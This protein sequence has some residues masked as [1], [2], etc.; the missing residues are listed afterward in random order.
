MARY[1]DAVCK[2]CRRERVKLFLK[3]DRCYSDKCAVDKKPY[4]PGQHGPN[5]RRAKH[6]EYGIQLR[7]KQKVKRLYG[8]LEKQ[9]R[10][11]YEK[12]SHIKGKTGENL[13]ILLERRLDNTV[14]RMGFARSLAEARQLVKHSHVMVNGEK[15]NIPSAMV[16]KDDVL[17]IREKSK[18]I[19]SIAQAGE[20]AARK[21]LVPVWLSVDHKTLSGK[22]VDNPSREQIAVPIQEQLIVEL[23]SR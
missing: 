12:A 14:F 17:T 15:C 8:L 4:A 19:A 21:G 13:L 18:N 9:F 10:L 22:V 20:A 3:G 23:Y 11:T 6:S 2:L 1:R 16:K 5:A 7:E